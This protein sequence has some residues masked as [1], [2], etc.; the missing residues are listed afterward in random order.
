MSEQ[1]IWE[2]FSI[3]FKNF[4][5][6]PYN[7]IE[8]LPL[9]DSM[10]E[11]KVVLYVLRHT[12]GFQEFGDGKKITIDEFV[13]GRKLK[14]RERMDSGTGLSEKAVRLG[15]ERA[16]NH[17]FLECEV[18]DSDLGR[19][20]RYFRLSVLEE[21]DPQEEEPE[22]SGPRARKEYSV[23]PARLRQ[24]RAMP[25]SEY[26]QTPEWQKKRIKAL[27]FAQFRCQ[28]CNSSSNL[29]T[30]HRSYKDL[31]QE[32]LSDITV[33]CN[34]CHRIFHGN[35]ELVQSEP[36]SNYTQSHHQWW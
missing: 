36:P 14:N 27:R 13:Q 26:L 20:K 2:G 22:T 25:Y 30:H 6:V 32:P 31:G 1:P 33:L 29:D 8:A 5:K 23:S 16:I 9:M 34:D 4:F 15:I 12:W 18:D 10:A 21:E 17:G 3:P 24:L 11:L 19:I 35:R 28:V 7:F